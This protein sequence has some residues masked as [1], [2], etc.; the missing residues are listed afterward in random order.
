MASSSTGSDALYS[1][2]LLR[3]SIRADFTN[4]SPSYLKPFL[5][6][7]STGVKNDCT[8]LQYGSL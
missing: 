8:V 4:S 3:S 1:I 5:D 7:H 2:F 6:V